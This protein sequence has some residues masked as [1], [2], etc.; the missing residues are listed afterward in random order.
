MASNNLCA[1]SSV[2][3]AASGS[4]DAK[5]VG[6]TVLAGRVLEVEAA[7]EGGDP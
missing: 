3:F 4:S 1:S 2:A 5:P 6:F 7:V